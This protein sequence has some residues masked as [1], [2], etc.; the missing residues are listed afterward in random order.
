MY[1]IDFFWRATRRWP[2][3]IAIDAPDGVMTYCE[4]GQQVAAAA[5]AYRAIDPNLQSRVGICAGNSREHL[6]ALLAVLASG[7]VW[8]PLNPGSTQ[9]EIQRIIDTT[10]P[11]ILVID[12]VSAHLIEPATGTRI[13]CRNAGESIDLS[14][15]AD[16]G[17]DISQLQLR[18]L[19]AAHAG[20]L[21]PAFELPDSAT[22]AIKFTGGTTGVPKGVMQPYRAWMAN[23]VN[24]IQ[25]WQFDE[26]D[27]YI[28]AA[29]LTH[30]TSTYILPILA[31]G[32][33]HVILAQ[34][35]AQAVRAAFRDRAGTVCFMPPTMIYM[36]MGLAGVSREDF[37]QLR[38]LIYGGA[39][40]PVEK[41]R[42][43]RGF[44][45]PVLATTYGQTE[46][47][48]ILTVMR[49]DD[50]ADPA[51]WSSVGAASWFSEVAI[52]APDGRLLPSGEIG[53]VVARGDLLMTGYWKLP[54]KTAET[55]VDGWLHTGDRGYIDETG[56]LYLKDRIRD[57]VITGGFNVYPVDVENALGQHPAV[58]ESSVFGLPDEKWGEAVQAAVQLRPDMWVTEA[59]L[60]AFVREKLGPVHTPKQIHFYNDLPRSPVGK[61][62]KSVVRET[63]LSN[64]V[65]HHAS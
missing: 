48:Q 17:R 6:I 16:I 13:Y 11:T 49:P 20:A 59:E 31:Q 28:V 61:V 24:Q 2:N 9:P 42:E 64:R 18:D 7:K 39:P 65:L 40:M 63:L 53:E 37:P 34:A 26:N 33:C 29:P 46:A 19:I 52:M 56:F 45:G 50:F 27:R 30:G 35:G 4:L 60:I 54:E 3:R 57:V 25:S 44:F 51:R 32:G 14:A 36:L 23:V 15:L 41:I 10:Q 58:H 22:Q 55:L 62:A 5:A 12:V 43:A 47:P 1:P 21:A 38:L 8:V